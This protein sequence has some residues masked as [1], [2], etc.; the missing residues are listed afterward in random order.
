MGRIETLLDQYGRPE[1]QMQIIRRGKNTTRIRRST[2]YG[3]SWVTEDEQ[4]DTAR[5]LLDDGQCS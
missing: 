1:D 4:V 5:I 2:N 3:W